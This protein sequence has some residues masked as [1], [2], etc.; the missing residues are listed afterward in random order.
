M[1]QMRIDHMAE[2]M[3]QQMLAKEE[4]CRS[5]LELLRETVEAADPNRSMQKGYTILRDEEG[6]VVL[7]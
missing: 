5:R 1:E 4:N 2:Q 6:N 3:K 7:E